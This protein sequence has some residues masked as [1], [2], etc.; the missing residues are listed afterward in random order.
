MGEYEFAVLVYN[1]HFVDNQ[2]GIVGG[3]RSMVRLEFLDQLERIRIRHTLYLSFVTGKF[4]FR[5]WLHIKN[6][7]F[8]K[9]PVFGVSGSIVREFPDDVIETRSK[10]VEDFSGQNAKTSRNRE[11]LEIFDSLA[12]LIA[13]YLGHDRVFAF[14][15]E[16]ANLGLKIDDVLIGPF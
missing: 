5:R 6:G 15:K 16:P 11:I 1:V 3:N 8:E 2:E 12:M 14:L 13:V 4:V 7:E 10:M 9:P